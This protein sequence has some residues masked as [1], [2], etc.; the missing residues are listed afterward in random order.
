LL[1]RL[2][3]GSGNVTIKAGA[4]DCL[5]PSGDVSCDSPGDTFSMKFHDALSQ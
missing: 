3:H 2:Q 5:V 1:L 4:A